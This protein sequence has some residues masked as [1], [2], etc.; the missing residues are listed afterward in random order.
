[1]SGRD[2]YITPQ[3]MG[4]RLAEL[5][6]TRTSGQGVLEFLERERIVLPVLRVRW[7][8]ALVIEERGG[9]PPMPATPIERASA[10]ALNKAVARWRRFDA[11]PA[12]EHPF[13]ISEGEGEGAVWLDR[14]VAASPFQAWGDFLTNVKPEGEPPLRVTDAVD[15]YYH[16]WQ[17]MLIADALELGVHILA[18]TRRPEIQAAIW[19]G[20]FQAIPAGASQMQV[21]RAHVDLDAGLGWSSYFDAA[22]RLQVRREREFDALSRAHHGQAFVVTPAEQAALV[23]AQSQDAKARLAELGN[24]RAKLLGF[25]KYLCERWDDWRRRDRSKMADAYKEEL[26]Q[27]LRLM[28]SG[29]NLRFSEAAKEVGR[30]TGHFAQTL[31][32]IFPDWGADARRKLEDAFKYAVVQA[33]ATKQPLGLVEA[34]GPEFVAWLE[35][36]DQWKGHHHVDAII[37]HQFKGS[38]ADHSGLAK[39]IE[40]LGLTVEHVVGE[41]LVAGGKPSTD[42]L[43]PK[44][45]ALWAGRLGIVTLL[46]QHAGLTST[47][48]AARA[49]Q[50]TAIN[51]L[52]GSPEM[53]VVQVLLRTALYR[54]DGAHNAM[55]G[56][57]EDELHACTA[58]FLAAMMLCR[59]VLLTDPPP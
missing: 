29:F 41:L 58:D 20:R 19:E 38:V 27:A 34:D 42:T 5:C 9:S 43:M 15:T 28:M 39:E 14:D 47:K 22:A 51:A 4:A 21:S 1:M 30:V 40:G 36:T 57:S 55:G 16:R 50:E 53:P 24:D 49:V 32:V 35:S 46:N 6:I 17:A 48:K 31:D 56:W 11:D 25:I 44:L 33:Q 26:A 8:E 13:D 54:N 2:R 23:A 37:K 10:E 52:S 3:E 12:L 7:P 45:K 59:K 18:D